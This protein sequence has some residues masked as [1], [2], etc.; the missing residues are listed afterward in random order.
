MSQESFPSLGNGKA[1]LFGSPPPEKRLLHSDWC[2]EGTSQVTAVEQWSERQTLRKVYLRKGKLDV[3]MTASGASGKD[4][5]RGLLGFGLI[6]WCCYSLGWT[7][8]RASED[9]EIFYLVEIY[10]SQLFKVSV[11]KFYYSANPWICFCNLLFFFSS[12]SS[13]TWVYF[14]ARLVIFYWISTNIYGNIFRSL[15]Y[16]FSSREDFQFHLEG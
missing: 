11:L 2:K 3:L 9:S 5:Q 10:K 1:H 12:S 7:R 16:L 4:S 8:L 14:L 15:G 6:S 13:F